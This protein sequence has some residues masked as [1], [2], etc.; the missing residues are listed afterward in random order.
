[1]NN[2]LEQVLKC[3]LA[4]QQLH[5]YDPHISELFNPIINLIDKLNDEK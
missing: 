1:M 5:S 3:T 4:Q 2:K